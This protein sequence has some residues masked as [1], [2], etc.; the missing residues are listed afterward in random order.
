MGDKDEISGRQQVRTLVVDDFVSMQEAL[1]ACLSSLPGVQVVGTAGNGKE[2]LEKVPLLRP[3][4]AIVDLQMPV[5]DGFQLM[6][7]LRR[8]YPHI[9]LVAVCGHASSAVEQE[10]LAAG[11]HA[12][13]AKTTLPQGLL[14]KL[15][16]LL[17][18]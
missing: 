3:D 15:E 14:S 12:F 16:A 18:Q 8:D 13:V 7:Q 11:A 10:A 5:M 9:R 6:R 2:A 17:L 4:L 1:S